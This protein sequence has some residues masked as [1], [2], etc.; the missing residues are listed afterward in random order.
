[1][2]ILFAQQPVNF[3]EAQQ[4]LDIANL[5]PTD[6]SSDELSDISSDI[7]ER[8]LF[9]ARVPSADY[10]DEVDQVLG[11][12]LAGNIDQATAR[13]A[14]K[15][16]LDEIGYEPSD[17][18]EGSIT[19]FSSDERTN[20]VIETNLGM[21]QGYGQWAQ[22]QS[23]AVLDQW[24]A[25]ELYRAAAAQHPR[26]WLDRWDAAGGQ[27]FDGRMIALKNTSI[28]SAISRFNLP[29]PPFD[30]GSHMDV[31]DVDRDTAV[32]LGLIDEDTQIAPETRDFNQDLQMTADIRSDQLRQVLIDHGY[33]FNGNVLTLGGGDES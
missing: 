32:S 25:Q 27:I 3:A 24:P 30:F 15:D 31:R 1:M 5:L 23:E 12:L 21:A 17:D 20:L 28:W 13:L 9:S 18:E 26:D 22:G 33:E 16:K 6:L 14:L 10:L 11:D 7:L 19:D 4:R 8:S 29:Y 2:P